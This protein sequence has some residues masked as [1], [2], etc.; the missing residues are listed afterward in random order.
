M[1][2]VVQWFVDRSREPSTAVA[3][4]GF[5]AAAGFSVDE[6]VVRDILVGLAALMGLLGAVLGEKGS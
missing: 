1:R 4:A 2:N 5:L 6:G 3:V